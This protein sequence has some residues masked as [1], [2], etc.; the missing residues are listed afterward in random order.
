MA[1]FTKFRTSVG[2][3]NRSD[4]AD[5]IEA[6]CAEQKK[7]CK[8]LEEEKQSLASQLEEAQISLTAKERELQELQQK[9]EETKTALAESESSLEEALELIDTQTAQSE[10]LQTEESQT[11]NPDYTSKELEA[12]R[13]AEATERLAAERANRLRARLSGLVDNVS[14]RYEQTGQEIQALGEDIRTNLQRM[15]EA[16][17]DLDVIFDEATDAFETLDA[18]ETETTQE[19]EDAE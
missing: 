1:D 17:S 16:L 4:V 14:G 2:G 8:A 6:L 18:S 11:E 10:Q 9:L 12:Y 7:T 3:F 5:Y 15:Q 13:R 19:Q